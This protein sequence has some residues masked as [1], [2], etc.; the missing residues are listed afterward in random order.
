VAIGQQRLLQYGLS[1]SQV[2][3]ALNNSNLN[4]GAQTV[5]IGPQSAVV[6]GA[7]QIHSRQ[8][9]RPM[10][11]AAGAEAAMHSDTK[12]PPPAPAQ[13]PGITA[14]PGLAALCGAFRYLRRDRGSPA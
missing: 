6:R 14:R 12:H 5:N 8:L 9:S 10:R 11:L 1:L 7:G 4:V 2:L 3:A 13:S